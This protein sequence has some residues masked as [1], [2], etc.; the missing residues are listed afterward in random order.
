MSENI[1]HKLIS[2]TINEN[3]IKKLRFNNLDNIWDEDTINYLLIGDSFTNGACVNSE[4]KI[5]GNLKKLSQ[6]N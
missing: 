3:E 5:A 2:N 6:K 1:F 4:D